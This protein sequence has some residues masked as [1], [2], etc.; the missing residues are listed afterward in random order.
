MCV[1]VLLS[2]C[3]CEY[4]CTHTSINVL[5]IVFTNI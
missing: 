2:V 4:A 3:M 1:W 5:T